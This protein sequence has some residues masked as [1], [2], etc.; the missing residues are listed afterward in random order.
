M[1]TNCRAN[2]QKLVHRVDIK[3]HFLV[4]YTSVVFAE[5]AGHKSVDWKGSFVNGIPD[6][7]A[8]LCYGL[9]VHRCHVLIVAAP[10]HKIRQCI[11]R[12]ALFPGRGDGGTEA[13]RGRRDKCR[14]AVG[15]ESGEGRHSPL[16]LW[17][18]ELCP[19]K[20]FSKINFEISAFL[21][22]EMVLSA[23]SARLLISGVTMV[24]CARG[25]KQRS[26]P[27]SRATDVVTWSQLSIGAD[28]RK[29][30]RRLVHFAHPRHDETRR[31]VTMGCGVS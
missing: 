3:S 28:E 14:R 19:Q 27:P 12:S 11:Q 16:P 6:I 23:V 9:D 10:D 2:G 25:Q 17:G 4:H 15:V 8:I 5:R 30:L 24:S 13:Q 21:Q 29:I 26:A 1:Y 20:I 7:T 22:T 18:L 31:Y